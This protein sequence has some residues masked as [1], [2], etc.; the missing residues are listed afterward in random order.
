MFFSLSMQSYSPCFA[1]VCDKAV[2]GSSMWH[3]LWGVPSRM[4]GEKKDGLRCEERAA[5]T[6]AERAT[7]TLAERGVIRG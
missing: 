1:F 2:C 7:M 3:V 6:L 5:M 4:T